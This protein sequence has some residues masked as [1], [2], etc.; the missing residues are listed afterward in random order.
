MS[1]KSKPSHI[2]KGNVLDDLGLSPEEAAVVKLKVQLHS[3]IMKVI[4]KKKLTSR[5]IEK[6]LDVPQPRVSDLLNGK[7]SNVS[8][9]KLTQY[10][11]KLGRRVEVTT[12]QAKRVIGSKAA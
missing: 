4:N 6:L 11:Y 9:D 3:E 1:V 7:I 12:K 10:L 2:S 5:S 8:S